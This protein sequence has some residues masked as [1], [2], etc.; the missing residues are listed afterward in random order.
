MTRYPESLITRYPESPRKRT[1][2]VKPKTARP[3]IWARIVK[4][5]NRMT[6]FARLDRREAR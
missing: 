5:E 2:T 4:A 3:C 1:L 6:G